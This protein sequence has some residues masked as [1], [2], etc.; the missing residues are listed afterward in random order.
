[1]SSP[2]IVLAAVLAA[3]A[4][5]IVLVSRSPCRHESYQRIPAGAKQVEERANR[6]LNGYME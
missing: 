5:V 4:V 1:M 2:A 3:V 6:I